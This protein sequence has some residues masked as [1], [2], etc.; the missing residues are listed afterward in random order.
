MVL[1]TTHDLEIIEPVIDR[2]VVLQSGRLVPVE[3]GV[4]TLRERYRRLCAAGT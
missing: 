3:P 1:V 2:A 4:G